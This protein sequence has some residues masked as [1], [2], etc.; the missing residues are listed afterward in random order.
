M[1]QALGMAACPIAFWRGDW[2]SALDN[3][4]RLVA[5]A[6][7]YT[8]KRWGQLGACYLSVA[9]D[10]IQQS[11]HHAPGGD[12]PALSP[13]IGAAFR[14][15]LC[16]VSGRWI[17]AQTRDRAQRG[18][19]GWSGP[20]ILRSAAAS[21]LEGTSPDLAAAEETFLESLK[22]ARQQNSL[23]WELRTVVSLAGLW[24]RQDRRAEAC[25]ALTS[26]Y[27]RFNEGF[28]TRDLKQARALMREFCGE[29]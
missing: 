20:E 12:S 14:E 18:L 19:C 7:R 3:S 5:H 9:E 15:L 4:R 27:Q 26:T 28:E 1:C 16:T 21:Q 2:E 25:Q 8:L 17:D 29:S 11:V 10:L 23:G 22:I 24:R 13:P 6:R